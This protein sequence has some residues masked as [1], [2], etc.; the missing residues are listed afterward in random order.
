SSEIGLCGPRHRDVL[1]VDVVEAHIRADAL[2]PWARVALIGDDRRPR[3]GEDGRIF[4]LDLDPKPVAL[5]VGIDAG[6]AHVDLDSPAVPLALLGRPPRFLPV[7]EANALDQVQTFRVRG[8]IIVE[9]RARPGLY[10]D[11]V[12]DEGVALVMADRI[13]LPGGRHAFG[14]LAIEANL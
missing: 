12:D 13:A 10:A 8:S 3:H 14:V 9:H 5:V 4:D 7:D 6:A 2:F 11:G 1:P